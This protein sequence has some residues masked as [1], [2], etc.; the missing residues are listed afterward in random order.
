MKRLL[1]VVV[2]L[3]A[4]L[5]GATACAFDGLNSMPIPGSQGTDSGAYQISAVIPTAAGLNT[6]APVMIDDATVGSVGTITVDDWHAK[7][8]IRLDKGTLVPR[9]SH[10]MVGMTSVLGSSH[11]EIVQPENPQGGFLAA[12][13][14]IPLTKC[15]EQKNISTP[16]DV[17]A[18]PDIN[19]SQEVAACTYP[20]TEQVLSSLS[21]VLNG[22]GLAQFGDIVHELNGVFG[23]RQEVISKL[24]PRLNTLVGDLNLQRDNIIS[25]MEGLDRLSA[26]INEQT[27]TVERA[28]QQGPQILQ[29]LVDQRQHFVDTLAALGTLSKTTN[30]ILD[31]N[32][33]DIKTIVSN[34]VPV[35]DQLQATGP[36]L[37]QSL[38]IFLTFPFYEKAI[39]KIVKGDYLNSELVLDVSFERLGKGIL[40]SVGLTGPE[41]VVGRQAGAARRGL[42]PFTSPLDPDGMRPRSQPTPGRA[43]A[44]S[45]VPK[46][47]ASNPSG[48]KPS[49]TSR[50]PA[51]QPKTTPTKPSDTA[52]DGGGN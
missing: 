41:A 23:G 7:V 8:A 28:L 11:L 25:A 5:V 6:N 29:L 44:S 31:A 27:P 16:T 13:D 42:N 52:R 12:G 30:D 36:A 22:G 14:Q 3:V 21:V 34:L 47:S 2:A 46:A 1:R 50:A 51:A 26:R 45:A 15:P 40:N 32:E 38:N 24:I 19:S 20:T 35:L 18:V 49:G 37:T 9:G 33:Q 17:P 10:V 43:P 4:V 39:P 48:V